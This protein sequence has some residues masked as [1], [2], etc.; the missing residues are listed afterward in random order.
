MPGG[1]DALEEVPGLRV[2]RVQLQGLLEVLDRGVELPA[3]HPEVRA[4]VVGLRVVRELADRLLD[5]RE[6]V[7]ERLLPGL[8]LDLCGARKEGRPA[9]TSIVAAG[10]V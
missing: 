6:G 3:K 2:V 7:V 4:V 9:C 10:S 8:R 1:L 5:R